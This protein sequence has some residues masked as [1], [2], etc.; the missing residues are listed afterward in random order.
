MKSLRSAA[1]DCDAIGEG[2]VVRISVVRALG[3]TPREIGAAMIVGPAHT[4]D[5]IGGGA[6]ELAAITHARALLE[7]KAPA[8]IWNR[9]IRDFPLGPS[10][11]QCCGGHA[12]L[13]FEVLGENERTALRRMHAALGG[14]HCIALR[15]SQAGAPLLLMADRKA[16]LSGVPLPVLHVARDMLSGARPREAAVV[17]PA[18]D[19]PAWLVEP[20][21]DSA[22]P[23]YIYGA[24]HV[25][26]AIV[27]VL[28]DLPL[29]I[30]WIDTSRDRFPPEIPSHA[31]ITIAPNP[32]E[33]AQAAPA[34]ALH[35]VLTF[36]HALDFAITFAL[37]ARSDFRFLGLIGSQTKRA[38]FLKRLKDAGIGDAALARLTC[39]IGALGLPGKEPAVI[40]IAVAAQLIG[41]QQA[42]ATSARKAVDSG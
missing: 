34:G 5:T 15:P 40:A 39:P 9:D 2:T 42:E 1:D 6:L 16:E 38:R 27:H 23:L 31:S 21:G 28:K 4:I 18:K 29:D 37:L 11:G 35:L 30:R 32:V 36:S 22:S 7:P 24:G 17:K 20:Y 14:Q 26:R 25:G 13:L 3:S 10:L 41:L 8:A 19:A 12:Q 33:V